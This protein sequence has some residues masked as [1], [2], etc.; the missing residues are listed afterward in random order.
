MA[1][2]SLRESSLDASSAALRLPLYCTVCVS[3]TVI[4][5]A[6]AA[7][8]GAGGEITERILPIAAPSAG[9]GGTLASWYVDERNGVAGHNLLG[10]AQHR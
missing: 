3:V 10:E 7:A 1:A 4:G 9:P 5:V 8:A 6:L 2:T